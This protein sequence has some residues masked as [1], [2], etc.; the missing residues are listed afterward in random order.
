M[1]RNE[2]IRK[3]GYWTAKIQ[4]DLFKEL[5]E[6]MKKN[7]LTRTKL[8][9]RLGVSKGYITQVLNGDFDHRISKLVDLSLSIGKVPIIEFTDI[10]EID[11]EIKKIVLKVEK[12]SIELDE[13][14][15]TQEKNKTNF[16]LNESNKTHQPMIT[17]YS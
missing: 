10:S 8:A 14:D 1:R 9:K 17:N 12:N 7:N 6:Y 15:S 4:I 5:E 3:K 16:K 2:L 13:T 11:S